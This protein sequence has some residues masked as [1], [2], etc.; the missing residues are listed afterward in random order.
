MEALSKKREPYRRVEGVVT[1][2]VE[3]DFY[4]QLT[5]VGSSGIMDSRTRD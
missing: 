1:P 5:I 4:V 2:W 3:S